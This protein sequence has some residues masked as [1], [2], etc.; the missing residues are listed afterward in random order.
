VTSATEL[1]VVVLNWRTPAHTTRA[2]RALLGDGVPDTR[3]VI[4]DNG[5]GDGTAGR[6]RQELS[7][8]TTIALDENLGFARA[9]N[10]GARVLPGKAYLFVNSDAFVHTPGSVGLLVE[11]LHDPRVGVAVPRLLNEDLTLQPSVVPASKPVPELVR[12]SGLSRFIPNRFQPAL[13]THW[14]HS[15]S[16]TIQA[17]IGAVLLIRGSTWDELGGFGERR[18]MYA[19]ELD[20]FWRAAERGWRAQFVA[21]A[22]F[23]HLGGASAEQR[24]GDPQRAELVARAHAAMVRSHLGPVR[25]RLTIA[26]MAMGAGAR[27]VFHR[28]RGDRDAAATQMAWFRGFIRSSSVSR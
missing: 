26:L 5:S 20:L 17:A 9:N 7:G 6:F 24:W 22:E 19:E 27:A 28:I 16:R 10:I 14:D 3:I 12:A 23:I 18:F 15:T 13:G 8:C 4:V 11:A 2:V 25:A 1:T 21:G